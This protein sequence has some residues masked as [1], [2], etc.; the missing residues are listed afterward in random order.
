MPR[1][2]LCIAGIL[3]LLATAR[4]PAQST[5]VSEVPLGIDWIIVPDDNRMSREK[6]ELG[7]QLFFDPRLSGDQTVSCATC[8]NPN[9][10]WADNRR[11]SEGVR[12]A[13]TSRNVPSIVNV[14]LHRTFFWD[15]RA[16]SLEEQAL[17]PLEN[18]DEMDIRLDQ[19]EKRLRNIAGYRRQFDTLFS[20]G[21]TAK[22]VARA[23]AAFQRTI[24][25]GET[26]YDRFRGGHANALEGEI[27]V[28][29]GLFFG[30]AHCG[31]CHIAKVYTDHQFHNIGSGLETGQQ[32]RGLAQHTGR[33]EDVGKFRTP[34]L[35][36]LALTAPYF[37]DGSKGTL[38]EV[39]DFYNEG[40]GKNP[41]LDP[42]IVPLQLTAAEKQALVTFLREGL[43]SRDY[44]HVEKPPLPK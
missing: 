24:V 19:L 15:G 40:G 6:V 11:F 12:G 22:N 5:Y 30:K 31:N 21:V 1:S 18:R 2:P 27:G 38:E 29:S 8:H 13:K 9:Q 32:D 16:A 41:N 7:K 42:H 4:L 37:H 35:R 10:G 20:D 33:Q 43:R 39:V 44:P 17:F 25:A 23:L 28:G 36:D 34:L 3:V 14:G 26:P